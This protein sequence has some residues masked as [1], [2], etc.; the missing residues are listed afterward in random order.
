MQAAYPTLGS[1]KLQLGTSLTIGKLAW[2]GPYSMTHSMHAR[3][4]Y[5]LT[6][7]VHCLAD[8]VHHLTPAS[9]VPP[10][11]VRS[12]SFVYGTGPGRS[13]ASP[14]AAEPA[15]VLSRLPAAHWAWSRV[16]ARLSSSCT[17]AQK[18]NFH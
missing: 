4:M 16:R 2:W 6:H 18:R 8:P 17:G 1:A 9:G 7:S 5:T 11:E 3:L 10:H 15:L 12:M 14:T 13:A